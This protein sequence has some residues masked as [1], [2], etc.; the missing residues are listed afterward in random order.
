MDPQYVELV[1]RGLLPGLQI[2]SVD[3]YDPVLVRQVPAPWEFVGAGNYA[4]VFAH[5]EYPDLVTKV[6]A[7]GRPGL[8]EEA[9]VYRKL[10]VHPAYARCFHVGEDYLVLLRLPGLTFYDCLRRGVR[11]PE[12][13]VRDIDAA[14]A[15]AR[16]RGLTP[17][18][19][20]A[21][22]VMLHDGRGLVAD[23]SDFK[24]PGSDTKWNDF[25]RAFYRFYLP[26]LGRRPLPM[27]EFLLN[28]I[29][30]GYR[31]FRRLFSS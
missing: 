22:N 14:L 13:A 2:F 6:Y 26:T 18:D 15:H 21:K 25:R 16:R 9:S 23:V 27:P 4:A 28:L 10:G 24:K 7:P 5:P 1:E 17:R 20:H 29:R 19:V 3:P 30:K 12:Q 11:I 8:V 31:R